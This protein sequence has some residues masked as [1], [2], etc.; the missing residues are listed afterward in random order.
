VRVSSWGG[1]YVDQHCRHR[2]PE[3]AESARAAIAR[4]STVERSL[5]ALF[6]LLLMTA[7]AD[8]TWC[9]AGRRYGIDPRTA[10]V[11]AAAAVAALATV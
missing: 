4:V 10:R 3:R 5:G 1:I 2:H 7:V 11:W 6:P 8:L 9:E